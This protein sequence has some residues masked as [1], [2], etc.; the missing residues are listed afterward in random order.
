MRGNHEKS[1]IWLYRVQ[2]SRNLP[3]IH[4]SWVD[5]NASRFDGRPTMRVFL[6]NAVLLLSD[7]V[8]VQTQKHEISSPHFQQ[9]DLHIHM[10]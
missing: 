9:D 1:T 8:N 7:S 10:T 5:T 2:Y 3:C 4:V 6:C